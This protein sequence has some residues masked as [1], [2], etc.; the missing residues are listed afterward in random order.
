MMQRQN[1]FNNNNNNQKFIFQQNYGNS[2]NININ[3]H[4][5]MI[6]INPLIQKQMMSLAK[7]NNNNQVFNNNNNNNN[8]RFN[9]NM[10]KQFNQMNFRN[11]PNYMGMEQNNNDYNDNNFMNNFRNDLNDRSK[12]DSEFIDQRNLQNLNPSQLHSQFNK[13]PINVLDPNMLNSK[14]QEELI[15]EIADS[16]YEIVY[17]KYPDEASKITG[18]IREKGYEKMNMLLSKREDLNEL[19]DKAYEMIKSN[20]SNNNKTENN[21]DSK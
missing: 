6:P 15:N 21:S 4:S 2:Y 13:P 9:N 1:V 17:S 11:Q 20:R 7:H 10:R 5:N 3:M 16:I 14:E 18:M 12:N 19:I 8:G